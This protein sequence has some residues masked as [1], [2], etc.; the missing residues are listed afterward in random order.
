MRG[1]MDADAY[2]EVYTYK[3]TKVRDGNERDVWIV[4]RDIQ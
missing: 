2:N 1:M 3:L 4:T